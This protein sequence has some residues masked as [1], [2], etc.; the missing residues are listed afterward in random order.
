MCEGETKRANDNPLPANGQR[1]D[2][3][4]RQPTA[5]QSIDG[6]KKQRAVTTGEKADIGDE[7]SDDEVNRVSDRSCSDQIWQSQTIAK[8]AA[9][10][11]PRDKKTPAE[12]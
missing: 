2:R 11:Q 9:H 8:P 6:A 10:N 5:L 1:H 12:S 7:R 4:D 3:K